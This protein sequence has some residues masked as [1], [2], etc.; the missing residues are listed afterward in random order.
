MIFQRIVRLARSLGWKQQ[1][2]GVADIWGGIGTTFFKE[3]R[4]LS[5]SIIERGHIFYPDKDELRQLF[6]RVEDRQEVV[7]RYKA[8]LDRGEFRWR[9]EA[10]ARRHKKTETGDDRQELQW[11]IAEINRQIIDCKKVWE[12]YAP[13]ENWDL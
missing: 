2:G 13:P 10:I 11:K 8:L 9:L 1:S 5:V 4:I 6:G 3:D 12:R 7:E